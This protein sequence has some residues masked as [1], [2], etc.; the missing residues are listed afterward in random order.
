MKFRNRLNFA[1]VIKVRVVVNSGQPEIDV[2]IY[3]NSRTCIPNISIHCCIVFITITSL[4]KKRSYS[5]QKNILKKKM[6]NNV[7]QEK[8]LGEVY[9]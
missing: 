4:Q 6:F 7:S 5:P 9:N 2:Y 1:V 3:K 8:Y